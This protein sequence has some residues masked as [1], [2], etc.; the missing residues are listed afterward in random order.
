MTSG[1]VKRRSIKRK[2]WAKILPKIIL[3]VIVAGAVL[4]LGGRAGR[5]F[6]ES[7]FFSVSK[8]E[9]TM[10]PFLKE[11]LS[12]D[13][14]NIA[15]RRF[16][17]FRLDIGAVSAN[18]GRDHPEFKSVVIL[19]RPPDVIS[20][21]IKYKHPAAFLKM[22]PRRK[23][24]YE[25]R[26]VFYGQKENYLLVPVSKDGV[27][28]PPDIL[29]FAAETQRRKIASLPVLAGPE[30][31]SGALRV[32]SICPDKRFFCGIGL[33]RRIKEAWP[34]KNHRLDV[35]DAVNL[36]DISMFLENGVEVKIGNG[37]NIKDKLLSLKN[38][39]N[40]RRFDFAKIKYIDLRF[41]DIIISP[42]QGRKQRVKSS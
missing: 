2:V 40:E 6:I 39:L 17:I 20:V 28:L 30:F 13:F 1:K 15:P 31:Q 19:R 9:L 41:S 26:Q 14:Y 37:R 16:N 29:D 38:I 25:K 33:L 34:I 32:G 23:F 11:A 5:F 7:E 8:V 35:L 10:K 21:K 4:F 3:A 42:K 36:K 27:I 24:F 22:S 18:V 12:L